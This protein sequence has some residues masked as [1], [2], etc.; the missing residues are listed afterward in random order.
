MVLA[1]EVA[2]PLR[3]AVVALAGAVGDG[4]RYVGAV[5]GPMSDE[6]VLERRAIV[7]VSG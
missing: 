2:P 3:I 6:A 7:E 5:K 1:D 4:G